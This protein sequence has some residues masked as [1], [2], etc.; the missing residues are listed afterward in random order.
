MIYSETGCGGRTLDKRHKENWALADGA[1]N[2]QNAV[3]TIGSFIQQL[4]MEH[5][6]CVMCRTSCLQ[7]S[8]QYRWD[9]PAST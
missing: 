4:F 2:H 9:F 6:L 7:S 1:L 5:L 8:E 3:G